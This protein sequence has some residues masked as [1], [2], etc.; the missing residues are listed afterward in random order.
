MLRGD[1]K[2]S[3][4]TL[5]ADGGRLTASLDEM[6]DVLQ[7]AWGPIL[8]LYSPETPEPSYGDFAKAF[9]EHVQH[10][11][12]QVTDITGEELRTILR[13]RKKKSSACGVDGWRMDELKALPVP[14]MDAFASFFNL[15]EKEGRWPE[16]L[17]T[18]LV[19]LIPK[20]ED[21]SPTNMRPITVTSC[22][23][24]LWACRRLRDIMA[25]QEEWALPTQHG[26][27]TGHRCDD[28]LMEMATLVEETLLDET[29]SLVV[30]ALD[31]AK[32][33]D[34]VP[35][36][37]VLRLAEEMGLDARIHKPLQAMYR[38]L[39]RRFKL[40]LG[41]GAYF[42]VTNGILQGCPISVI[43]INAL[44]SVMLRAVPVAS[45]SYADDATLHASN[46]PAVQKA[47][48]VV[49][50][51]CD[52]TGMRL[53]VKKTV[54]LGILE[55]K[56]QQR[57]QRPYRS[58]LHIG[59]GDGK[60]VFPTVSSTKVLS[61]RLN[62]STKRC[63]R[64]NDARL[65]AQSGLMD[66]LGLSP[67][68]FDERCEIASSSTLGSALSGCQYTPFT[69]AGLKSLRTRIARG[70]FG[71]VNRGTSRS[72][73]GAGPGEG[74]PGRP[75]AG[76]PLLGAMLTAGL[77]RAVAERARTHEAHLP[78]VWRTGRDARTGFGSRRYRD[79]RRAPPG[80]GRIRRV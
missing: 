18:A 5:R 25:W 7:Q 46:E 34:R 49:S 39:K 32:C 41:V 59:E 48:D 50:R 53:N 27:R 11:P 4:D 57:M 73:S 3:A 13:E 65:E 12:M 61:G 38:G 56:T 21:P 64:T 6:D 71:P 74:P 43:L 79:H 28:A 42:E 40:P 45:E 15:V 31:F 60:E 26:F 70:V 20:S 36:G 17:L 76:A 80:R 44:L 22:V 8:R 69:K 67:L 77:V 54:A 24:R 63:D 72:V 62:T 47:V 35:Q 33:F 1:T 9:G 16:G 23:Y 37:I 10:R 58:T 30:L 29:K 2:P 19:S 78:A 55:G 75:R 51:F 66:A 52:V 14:L 68:P